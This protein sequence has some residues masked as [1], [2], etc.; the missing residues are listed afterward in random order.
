MPGDSDDGFALRLLARSRFRTVREPSWHRR[1]PL[2]GLRHARR[3][4]P[5]RESLDARWLF[6][7][8][9]A[10][11][12]AHPPLRCATPSARSATG[13]AEQPLRRRWRPEVVAAGWAAP[14][15]TMDVGARFG[16]LSQS[17][18]HGQRGRPRRDAGLRRTA[19]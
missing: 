2:A 9:R 19:I 13:R 6:G 10:V 16:Y 11:V 15:I 3:A 4:R 8:A 14:K 18:A 12:A 7:E 17:A 5:G 1:G